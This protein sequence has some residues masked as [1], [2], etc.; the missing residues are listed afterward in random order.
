MKRIAAIV[1]VIS[2]MMCAQAGADEYIYKG[3]TECNM[4][5]SGYYVDGTTEISL[6]GG[7]GY[8]VED[9][10]EIGIVVGFNHL[11]PDG[12]GKMS[13]TSINVFY[14]FYP[15]LINDIIYPYVGVQGGIYHA[16][17]EASLDAGVI[18]GMKC[19]MRKNVALTIQPSVLFLNTSDGFKTRFGVES[20]FSMFF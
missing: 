6:S 14:C 10:H 16:G 13:A 19:F 2:A 3:V 4:M 9:V 8:F 11:A 1:A 5:A 12:G 20:G 18:G 7:V 17:N 15:S